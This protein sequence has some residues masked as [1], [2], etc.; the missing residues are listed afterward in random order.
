MKKL[1]SFKSTVNFF[2]YITTNLSNG[3]SQIAG[4]LFEEFTR[5][6]HLEYGDY[7]A[8]YDANDKHSIPQQ[9][10]DKIDAWELLDKGANSYG[11]DKICVTRNGGQIDIH[12]D[13]STLHIDKNLS[14][15]KAEGMMS[16]RNNPLKN[17]RH[18]VINTTAQDMS[19][20][21]KLWKD[22]PPLTFGYDKFVP[23]GADS[24][25]QARDKQFWHN[26]RLKRKGIHP[27]NIFGFVSRGSQQD[28]Y[29]NAGVNFGRTTFQNNGKPKWHQLGVGALGKSVLDPI[30]LAEL[31][32]LFDPIYTGTPYP[33]SVSFYHSSKTLP[34]NGWEEVMRRRAKGLYDEVI[35]ISGTA[36]VDGEN[37]TNLSTV[38]PKTT[39]VADAV[40][41]IRGALE[42]N[43]SVLLLTLYHHSQ[44]IADI[45][46]HLTKYYPEFRYWY[47]KRDECDWP[48]SNAD[49]SFAPA[50]DDRTESV[51]TF[52]SSGT[53]RL[54]KDLVNDYG[55]NNINIHGPCAHKFTW[56]QAED[57]GL[58]KPLILILPCVRESEV[59]SLFPEFTDANGRVD[60]NM[61]VKG[62]PVDNT[63]PTAGLIAD[64]VAMAKS[65]AEYPEVKRLL[66]FSHQVK[67]NKLAEVNW[68]WVCN[69]V[70]DH[71]NYSKSVKK[72]F[73]QVLNDDAYNSASVKDHTL[74]IRKAKKHNRYAIG[75]CKVFGRG[76]DD[77]F[78]PKHHAAI[79]FDGKT[80]VT[81]VQEIWRITR[82]DI[83]PNTNKPVCGDPNAYYILP[84][85]YNDIGDEPS[86]SEDRKQ[87]LDGILQ[88]NK[89]IFDE[90]QSLIQNPNGS[91]RKQV[92]TPGSRLWVPEDFDATSFAGLIT[93]ITQNSKGKVID[94]LM[95]EAHTWMLNQYLTTPDFTPGNKYQTT[96]IN[97]AFYGNPKFKP[98][99]DC[100]KLAK[101]SPTDFRNNFWFGTYVN[102]ARSTFSQETKDRITQ[103][104]IEY[105]MYINDLKSHRES[106]FKLIERD[107]KKMFSQI[108]SLNKKTF[109][110]VPV[111]SEKYNVPTHQIGK[112]V[113]T[114]LLK[115]LRKNS[116]QFK[117][118]QKTIYDIL[119][120]TA[121]D[122]V[123]TDD[124]AQ[125]TV[126]LLPEYNISNYGVNALSIKK[127]FIRRDSFK[128]LTFDER[129]LFDEFDYVVKQ[130]GYSM[131]ANI[132]ESKVSTVERSRRNLKIREVISGRIQFKTPD[133]IFE[134]LV[135][136]AKHHKVDPSTIGHWRKKDPINWC[137]VEM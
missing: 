48:C 123:G 86:F 91:K 95:V 11:I 94:S 136:A 33:V 16:L 44:Q 13:K 32:S 129:K 137:F 57:A 97:K 126:D 6:W 36:V 110:I 27:T 74:A 92:R 111:L 43:K 47:R 42:N 107:A 127:Q 121:A 18:F 115:V 24:E 78:S 9:I 4:K 133:G 35:V 112:K 75:S 106:K 120:I 17:I 135:S 64:L 12:Q 61:R 68:S 125:K 14:A 81:A 39:S 130:R 28:D 49:S 71:S 54:G 117:I 69:K 1:E 114:P 124:W 116:Q 51:I 77:K 134:S 7:V 84:L 15:R 52:G 19:S 132:R 73:W 88:H 45:K 56:S 118:L 10:V 50:L 26:I 90:F 25:S 23:D 122:A 87:Q 93:W 128:V 99:F 60:W 31:E 65:L 101:T 131:T 20:Y 109:N 59:A 8:I 66:T 108:Y 63:Y 113:V 72:L 119:L 53:E 3:N 55:I 62:I 22:H 41:R 21:S 5:E 46:K 98:I 100:Y 83:D 38:F 34:K 37:D 102:R 105:K 29:I 30:I 85:R 67:T 82:T 76:Y 58:V 79:H 96:A 103:N 89:N 40:V 70:L 104:L 2:D 80:I